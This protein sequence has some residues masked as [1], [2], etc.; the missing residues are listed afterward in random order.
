MFSKFYSTCNFVMYMLYIFQLYQNI[1][2]LR[3]HSRQ[4]AS[5]FLNTCSEKAKA[6]LFNLNPL[7]F[8]E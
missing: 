7:N 3:D 6:Y 2:I 5:P 1:V 8:L 4:D